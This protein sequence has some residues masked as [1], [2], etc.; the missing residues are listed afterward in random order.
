MVYLL[1]LSVVQAVT[2]TK[3][4]LLYIQLGETRNNTKNWLTNT[5]SRMR[6]TLSVYVKM[7]QN[8]YVR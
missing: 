3:S 7:Y 4:V 8:I 2:L 5:R 6:Y 1:K